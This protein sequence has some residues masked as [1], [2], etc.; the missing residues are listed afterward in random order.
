METIDLCPHCIAAIRSRGELVVEIKT[1]T[2]YPWDEDT[3][4]YTCEWC[5]EEFDE[6]RVCSF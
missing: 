6:I 3:E 4:P 2:V 5:E 1:L